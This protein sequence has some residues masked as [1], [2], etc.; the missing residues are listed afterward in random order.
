MTVMIGPLILIAA[1]AS[2]PPPVAREFRASGGATARA[3]ASVRVISGVS[4]G[5]DRSV[6]VSGATH[7][8]TRLID[9]EGQSRPANLLEFQ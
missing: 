1:I 3:S 6:V 9:A 7:R 4:F 5:A 8:S 2:P